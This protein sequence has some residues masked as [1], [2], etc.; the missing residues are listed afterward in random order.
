M[1]YD[2]AQLAV[3]YLEA[4]AATGDPEHAEVAREILDYSEREMQAPE[5]GHWSA[6]DADSPVAAGSEERAEGAF[7]VWTAGEIR[8]ALEPEEAALFC[9]HYGVEAKGNAPAGADPHGELR[10]K[11]V[12]I[13]RRSVAETARQA[14]LGEAE[15]DAMLSAARQKLFARRE[16]RPRPHLDDK[17]LAAW[18]GLMISAHARAA[19]LLGEPERLEAAARVARFVREHLYQPGERTLYRSWRKGRG[20]NEAFAEDYASV[21]AGALDL[22]EAGFDIQWLQWAVELQAALDESFWDEEKGGYWSASEESLELITRLKEDYDGAE[23]AASTVAALNLVRLAAATGDEA[24]R[25][26]ARRTIAA[27]AG[28]WQRAPHA[29]PQMLVALA[30]VLRPPRAFAIAGQPGSA[31]FR[32]L[33]A[34]ATRVAQPGDMLLAADGAAGQSWL[35]ERLPYLADARPQGGKAAAYICENFACQLPV[36]DPAEIS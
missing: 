30:A 3:A 11:N 10:D 24:Y 20:T 5:G 35:A 16:Q 19:R 32:A 31:D 7:Y 13:A 21:I 8:D 2:Q 29:L 6:E 22:Y 28:Q 9:S 25:E 4:F 26:R 15:A 34:A 1:L 23:P 27:F 12:L 36:T 14:G 18:N 17:L 33:A